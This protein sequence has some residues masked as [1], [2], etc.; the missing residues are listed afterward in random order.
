M[1]D[2]IETPAS[3]VRIDDYDTTLYF[4]DEQEIAYLQSAILN[5]FDADLRRSVVS[6]LLDTYEQEDDAGVRDE[7]CNVLDQLLLT[8]LSTMQFGTVAY[9]LR[10][11]STITGRTALTS[12]QHARLTALADRLSEPSVLTQLLQALDD[13]SEPE[14]KNDVFDAAVS[15]DI[16][17]LLRQLKPV[18][19]EPVLAQ[20]AR[21]HS[22]ELRTMLEGA[23]TRLAGSSTDELVQLIGS[24][25]EIVAL[26]AIHR[27]GALRSPAAVTQLSRILSNT[28]GEL[29]LAAAEALA[30][31][32]SAGAMQVLER[33]IDGQDR[34][35]RIVALHAL[36]DRRHRAAL[37]RVERA[38]KDRVLNEPASSEKTA[39]FDTYAVLAGEE[40]I[41]FLDTILNP[42]GFLK[43]KGDP[44]T[45]ACAAAALGKIGSARALDT[46]RRAVSDKE[47]VVRNAAS[48]AL[49]GNA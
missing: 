22:S 26:Q 46:L 21:T 27:S 20:L 13:L 47:I 28:N 14:M 37:K 45:R 8:L 18:A 2:V 40:G 44:Q 16:S 32:G 19:L 10:E 11:V 5:D 33:A 30:E 1:T 7:I 43:R 15:N 36:S 31:I 49:R 34:D 23:V 48:R 39:F 42:H 3:F 12:E 41:E 38:I 6:A 4:L 29:R 24:A 35:V 25:D 17:E 9:L